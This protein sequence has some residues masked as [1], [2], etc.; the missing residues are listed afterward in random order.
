MKRSDRIDF[1]K[2]ALDAVVDNGIREVIIGAMVGKL[3]KMAQG[4]TVTHANRN[5]VNTALVAELAA[6]VGAPASLCEE[7][8]QGQTARFATERLAALGLQIPFLQ[9]LARRVIETL[10]ARYPGRFTLRV[11]VCDFEGNWLTEVS[12]DE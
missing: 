12:E 3:T 1:L 4:E 2:A 7:I 9:L 10:R 8:R 6:A 11:L 5:P